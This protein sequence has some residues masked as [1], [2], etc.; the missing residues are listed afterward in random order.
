[1]SIQKPSPK[2]RKYAGQ[3]RGE[4]RKERRRKL[5]SAGYAL[6][7]TLGVPGTKI[8]L[9]CAKAGVGIRSLYEEFGSLEELFR[10]VYD[11]I[12]DDAFGRISSSINSVEG[13]SIDDVLNVAIPAYLHEMLD[14]PRSGRIVSIESARLDVELGSHRNDTLKRFAGLAA[15]QLGGSEMDDLT[16]SVWSLMLAGALKEIVVNAVISEEPVDVEQLAQTAAE[17]WR[18]SLPT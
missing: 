14:D 8:E 15:D 9:V 2:P 3:S 10:A 16:K 12:M 4:R 11:R 6:F 13:R 5:I 7:G 18:R 1:M 17:I